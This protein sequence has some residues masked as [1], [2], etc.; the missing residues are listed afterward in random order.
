MEHVCGSIRYNNEAV[1]VMVDDEGN[2]FFTDSTS[3]TEVYL[4]G[5][6]PSNPLRFAKDVEFEQADLIA[7]AMY[8]GGDKALGI[9]LGD[10]VAGIRFTDA[11][12]YECAVIK[13]LSP[14]V[15]EMVAKFQSAPVDA[16]ATLY[17]RAKLHAGAGK[18]AAWAKAF[19]GTEGA[20]KKYDR[21]DYAE[22]LKICGVDAGWLRDFAAR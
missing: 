4:E 6:V 14:P 21:T 2:I 12:S 18:V 10:T 1:P 13:E 8:S 16:L 15:E 11:G 17:F 19:M 20:A 3:N 9:V 7:S 22:L 5:E